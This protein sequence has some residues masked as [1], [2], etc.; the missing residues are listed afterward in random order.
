MEI[1]G[2]GCVGHVAI[3]MLQSAV[4]CTKTQLLQG[5]NSEEAYYY[6]AATNDV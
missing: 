2:C 1:F 5:E 4:P 6:R 3:H